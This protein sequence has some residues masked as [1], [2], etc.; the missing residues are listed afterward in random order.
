MLQASNVQFFRDGLPLQRH[1]PGQV[2]ASH[3]RL[4][5]FKV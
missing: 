1:V 2:A 3:E 5:K 4:L